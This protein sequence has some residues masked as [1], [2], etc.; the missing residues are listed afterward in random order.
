LPVS[1]VPREWRHRLEPL[2]TR[3]RRPRGIPGLW[4]RARRLFW[5]WGLW[6]ALAAVALYA[7]REWTAVSFTIV[8]LIAYLIAPHEQ[9]PAYGLDHETTINSPAFLP[10]VVG[11]TGQPMID[12]NRVR[13][14][15]N[16]DQFYPAMLNAVRAAA[17]SI[18]IEAYIYW[19]GRVGL[20]FAA[21]L[22]ERARSGVSVKILL[23]AVGSSTIGTE[24]LQILESG[25]C[26]LAWFNPIRP[27][28]VGRFNY[29]THRKTLVIDG[30]LG[31]TGGAGIADHWTGNAEN[32]E[33][34]RDMQIEIEGPGIVP[35]QTGFAQNW[36]QTTRELVSGPRFFPLNPA[37]GDV[38][39][40]GMLSSPSAGASA[41]RI[42]YY[43]AIICARKSILIANPYFIPDQ[44]AID[45]L[46]EARRRGVD[47]RV[48]VSGRFNDNWLA[49]H[50]SIRLCGPLL[51]AGIAIFEYDR[52]MLHH[53]TMVVDGRWATIGTTNFDNRSFA[54]NEESN[55]S[56]T[57]P[58]LVADL[59]GTYHA[60][61]A[62][63]TRLTLE[64]WRRRGLVQQSR[65]VLASFLQEQV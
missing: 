18:T 53:K 46:I 47:V 16:G 29:R 49:R 38:A 32:P 52:T 57:D 59:E 5:S 42:I 3:K 43:F 48:T 33:H 6:L 37:A 60:D 40:H 31:F 8:A 56:F 45:A 41:A 44:T 14:L 65:E 15:N 23:D 34:W 19:K 1:R 4:T 10:S 50:N 61:E 20:E 26:E 7:D 11:L 12:G 63:S 62:V 39:I 17:A 35:L 2:E 54:F 28:T 24:I 58:A 21:A 55:I 9:P 27:F 25:G 30:R 22:A 13:L 64:V 36:L 51:R